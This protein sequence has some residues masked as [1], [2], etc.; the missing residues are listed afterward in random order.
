MS[1][2]TIAAQSVYWTEITKSS[3]HDA[4][5]IPPHCG[6]MHLLTRCTAAL[7]CPV[8]AARRYKWR[9]G[10]K[11]LTND[12]AH[13]IRNASNDLPVALVRASSPGEVLLCVCRKWLTAL[14]DWQLDSWQRV[15]AGWQLHCSYTN[16]H[17]AAHYCTQQHTTAHSSTQQHTTAQWVKFR[18]SWT[19]FVLNDFH[20]MLKNLCEGQRKVPRVTNISVLWQLGWVCFG[21]DKQT[22]PC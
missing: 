20:K 6:N 8:Q 9:P 7:A 17:T 18:E 16:V 1:L 21:T 14:L 2:P 19:K 10:A 15:T 5:C 3:L 11:S 22:E 12:P 4:R 13:V